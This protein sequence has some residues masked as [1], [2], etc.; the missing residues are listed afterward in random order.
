MMRRSLLVCG[1]LSTMLYA[2]MNVV[3]P[4][5]W[6]EYSVISQTISELSAVGAPTRMLWIAPAI[7]YTL[8]VTAFGWGIW[9][10]AGQDR[11]MRVVGGLMMVYGASGI[12]WFF[13]PMHQREVLAAGGGTIEDTMHLVL[14]GVTSVLYLCALAFGAALFGKTFRVYTFATMALLIV[15]GVLLGIDGPKMAL[16]QP[17][18]WI[19]VT[20]RVMLGVVMLW[21]AVLSVMLLRDRADRGAAAGR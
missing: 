15:C 20:E 11:R 19:G 8:L 18:P 10:S 13:A 21:V 16:N 12:A 4:M 6:K 1:I 5:Q 14:S 17:T 7:V 3:V 2:A 9:T